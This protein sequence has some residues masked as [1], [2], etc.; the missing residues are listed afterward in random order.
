MEKKLIVILGPTA[1]GKT[2]LAVKLAKKFNGEIVSADSRQ[3]YKG[4]DIG[5]AKITKKEMQGISHHLL[6][7]A[8]PKQRFTVVRYQ[9]L[10]RKT[11][12]N[13]I[14]SQQKGGVRNEFEAF[15]GLLKY[16]RDE[17]AHGRQSNIAEREALTSIV[18][19]LRCAQF[20]NDNYE[21]LTG[22][23]L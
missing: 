12:E 10:A 20:A 13:M 7:V 21:T 11:I 8:S 1:S 5:T 19:L 2:E 16:W 18:L 6:D 23:K 3:V 14:T 22:K 9:K 4:L 17:A 15:F